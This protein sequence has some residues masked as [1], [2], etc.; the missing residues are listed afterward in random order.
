MKNRQTTQLF[1]TLT[2]DKNLGF[3]WRRGMFAENFC[4]RCKNC[5]FCSPVNGP[6]TFKRKGPGIF[7]LYPTSVLK[8]ERFTRSVMEQL[9][10]RARLQYGNQSLICESPVLNSTRVPRAMHAM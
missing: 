7:L 10:G 1:P 8:K 4:K 5:V 9:S 6:S 2:P 3:P